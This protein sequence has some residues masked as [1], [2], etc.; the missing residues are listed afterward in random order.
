MANSP[1]ST[2]RTQEA[3]QALNG[4]F[5]TTKEKKMGFEERAT[6]PLSEP[7]SF[8][9]YYKLFNSFNTDLTH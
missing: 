9:F 8:D 4:F 3:N 1:C 2:L 5:D 6:A 7:S